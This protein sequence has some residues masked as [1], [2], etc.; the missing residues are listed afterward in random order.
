MRLSRPI[1]TWAL[2]R[3]SSAAGPGWGRR[4][5]LTLGLVAFALGLAACSRS[6]DQQGAVHVL[7]ID[8]VIN[9]VTARYVERGIDA[10]EDSRAAA[11][12][13][14]L[15]TPGGLVDSMRDI[16]RDINASRV[17]VI[18]YVWPSGG[19]AASAGTFIT[20][21]GHVAAMAP[22]T[23]MGAASPVASGG[24]D[25][26]VSKSLDGAGWSASVNKYYSNPW[27]STRGGKRA[28][29]LDSRDDAAE[30]A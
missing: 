7:T 9:P 15:D 22:N 14:Q 19:R 20:M 23:N 6:F 17:P 10:A 28:A 11:V 8:G 26:L 5:R 30:D 21:A 16:V 12:V 18:T 13:V 25:I 29:R 1:G 27:L 4:A 2:G 24:Q 3:A